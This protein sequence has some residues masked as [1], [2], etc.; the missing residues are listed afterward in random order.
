MPFRSVLPDPERC[1]SFS[2]FD[3]AAIVVDGEE[4]PRT[5]S[6]TRARVREDLDRI[7]SAARELLTGSLSYEQAL[8]EYFPALRAAHHGDATA[9]WSIDSVHLAHL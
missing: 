4:G 5:P 1:P 3:P 8:R 9:I 7:V 2:Q 6:M